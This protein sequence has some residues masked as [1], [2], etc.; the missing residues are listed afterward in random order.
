MQTEYIARLCPSLAV[1]FSA[2]WATISVQLPRLVCGHAFFLNWLL[3][4]DT[5]H[6]LLRLSPRDLAGLLK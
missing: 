5:L 1:E 2:D 3:T 4:A 6:L